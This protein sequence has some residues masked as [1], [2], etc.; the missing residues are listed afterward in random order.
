MNRYWSPGLVS[1]RESDNPIFDSSE[2]YP[3]YD[4]ERLSDK[5]FQVSL[6]ENELEK[7]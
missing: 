4:V 7:A 3:L 1:T 2:G 5:T 6:Y